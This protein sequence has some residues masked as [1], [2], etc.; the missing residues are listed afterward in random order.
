MVPKASFPVLKSLRLNT[1]KDVSENVCRPTWMAFEP[2]SAFITKLNK[3][4]N[5]KFTI[6]GI[7][8][9]LPLTVVSRTKT[10]SSCTAPDWQAESDRAVHS[11]SATAPASLRCEASWG[12]SV[13]DCDWPLGVVLSVTVI[14]MHL[15]YRHASSLQRC[16]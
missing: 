7:V 11:V 9:S 12:R 10:T 4:F 14:D 13:S 15:P 1:V 8:S 3:A 5:M 2:I 6:P 16:I